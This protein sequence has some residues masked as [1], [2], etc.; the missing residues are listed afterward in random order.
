[1]GKDIFWYH[2][3]VTNNAGIDWLRRYFGPK[4]IRIHDIQFGTTSDVFYAY[5]LDVIMMPLRPGL[6]VHNPTRPFVTK[7][8]LKLL[9]MNDW[10]VVETVEPTHN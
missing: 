7:E 10:E 4:E 8:A 1:M 2:S 9:E 6:V 3:C 5:H